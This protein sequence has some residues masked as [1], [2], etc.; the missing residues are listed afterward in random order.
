MSQHLPSLPSIHRRLPGGIELVVQPLPGRPVA[1]VEIRFLGGYA[2]EDP[3][4]LGVT[5]VLEETLSKGTQRRDG[6][7]LNDAFD[8]IGATHATATGR[9]TL[10]FSSLVLPEF[11]RDTINLHAEMICTPSLPQDACEVAVELSRQALA[12][13]DDD[14]G[15]LVKKLLTAGAYGPPLNRHVLGEAQT[16][17]RIGRPQIVEHWQ[18]CLAPCRMQVA[19]AGPV[20]PDTVSGWIEEAFA[21]LAAHNACG[22]APALPLTFTPARAHLDKELEQEQ[23]LICFPGSAVGD[24]DFE[25]QAVLINLLGGGSMGGRLM[26]EV[27]EKQ[28]LVYWV[29]AWSDQPRHAG[30]VYLGASCTP[31]NLAATHATLLREISRV[32]CDISEAEVQRAINGLV[33]RARTRGDVTTARA[34]EA[35]LD[36]FYY[37]RPVPLEEKLARISAVTPGAICAWLEAHPRDQLAIATV[38]PMDLPAGAQLP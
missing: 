35:V 15:E 21:P 4:C 20:D 28:G 33:T 32:S 38:G 1:D 14:P 18:N 36:L 8:Q 13:L 24:A 34:G 25:V 29:G 6:R 17:E 10:G 23:I 22:P 9:E 12:A 2:F 11:V 31:E 16:L 30:V 26:N 7:A 27:R 5:Q 37:G 3:P 19:V